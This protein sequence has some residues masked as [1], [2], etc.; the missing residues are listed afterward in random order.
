ALTPA[1]PPVLLPARPAA[2]PSSAPATPSA[3]VPVEVADSGLPQ[4]RRGQ[5]LAATGTTTAAPAPA[6][7]PVRADA[8]SAAARFGA[9]RRAAQQAGN[10]SAPATT[11]APAATPMPAATSAPAATPARTTD[12]TPTAPTTDTTPDASPVTEK[13]S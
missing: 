2:A 4:R 5:T 7:K 8:V 1:G 10:G 9:F 3:P 13:D 11:P 6:G 12:T